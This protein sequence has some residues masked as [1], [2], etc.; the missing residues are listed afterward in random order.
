MSS[1]LKAFLTGSSILVT[2]YLFWKVSNIPTT[3]K[4]YKLSNYVIIA[5]IYL[6]MMNVLSLY[7][8][9]QF[10]LS[11]TKRYMSISVIAP[12]LVIGMAKYLKTYNFTPTEWSKYIIRLYI[13]YFIMFMVVI[14]LLDTYTTSNK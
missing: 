9:K 1:Y 8:Q 14:R 5:P 13:T 10:R 12:T 3:I 2:G 7:L 11:T 6:G 4:N